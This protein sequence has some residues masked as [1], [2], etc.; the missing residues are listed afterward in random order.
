MPARI[1]AR[2]LRHR[3]RQFDVIE[4]TNW[5]GHAAFFRPRH[6]KF[7]VRLST[8][9]V[10]CSPSSTDFTALERECCKN[11]DIVIGNS[12]AILQKATLLYGLDRKRCTVIPHGVS[13]EPDAGA[14][15]RVDGLDLLYVGR[16][17]RR[18][19]T[20]ILLQALPDVLERS[21]LLRCSFVGFESHEV[22]Q[23]FPELAGVWEHLTSRFKHQVRCMGR[24][25][26]SS[27]R[28]AIAASHWVLIPSR[29]ESFGLVAI[30]ALRAGTP[31]ITARSGGLV[32][33]AAAA[34]EGLSVSQNDP[35]TWMKT[36][37]RVAS[38]GVSLAES[39]R[40]ACRHRFLERF[41]AKRMAEDSLAT[42][43]SVMDSTAD[44]SSHLGQ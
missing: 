30:E 5:L 2:F 32:E 20:D 18:K 13:D 25:E 40:T 35:S 29:Y 6:S 12:Q 43:K 22:L 10:D 8:P 26:E 34:P 3:E 33:T 1:L 36:L 31:F 28:Q 16:C 44:S 42:Y 37:T 23:T 9:A 21:P 19:G 11:A 4:T 15:R 17:E 38:D 24:L 14:T 7:V 39:L 27:K 41:T